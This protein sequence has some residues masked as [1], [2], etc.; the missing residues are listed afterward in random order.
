MLNFTVI[1]V[2]PLMQNATLLWD[3]D[4][5]DAVLTDVGGDVDHLLSVVDGHRLNLREIWLTHAHIDHVAGVT[6]LLAHREVPVLGPHEADQFWL[7]ELPRVA[8]SYGFPSVSSF[9]PTRWLNEGDVLTVGQYEFQV[10]HI[11]GHTPG[12]LV[13]YCA[14]ENLLV[15]GDVLFLESVG[16][17]DFPRGNQEDL[18]RNIREKLFVL[19]DLT[20]V[21]TGHGALTTIGHEKRHNP[22]VRIN[23]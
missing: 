23:D 5:K 19:P 17:T 8:A 3:S 12:S 20:R 9:T 1:P 11:P 4:S 15:A 10:L 22:F 6:G 7:D 21:I 2:T 14:A 16:R 18:F 13:F